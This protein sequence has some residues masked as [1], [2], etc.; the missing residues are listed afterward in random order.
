MTIVQNQSTHTQ[1]ESIRQPITPS[2]S[3]YCVFGQLVWLYEVLNASIWNQHTFRHKHHQH[4]SKQI[5]QCNPRLLHISIYWILNALHV[6][7][8]VAL[9]SRSTHKRH[10]THSARSLAR[11][12]YDDGPFVHV[13]GVILD[14]V[15][16]AEPIKLCPG[17]RRWRW[18]WW[19]W[20]LLLL[21]LLLYS[22]WL[23]KPEK[24]QRCAIAKQPGCKQRMSWWK[25]CGVRSF[26]AWK[27]M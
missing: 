23:R 22:I 13:V 2:A 24:G 18:W 1:P 10:F 20:W 11:R 26:R 14:G 27:W 5:T 7:A 12:S 16:H 6:V 9:A 17:R 25:L 3:R 21:L 15:L 8:E 4:F 19:W